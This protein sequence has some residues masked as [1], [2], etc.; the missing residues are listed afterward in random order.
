[1]N[2]SEEY[3]EIDL[4]EPHKEPI[5]NLYQ[6]SKHT[7]YYSETFST[8]CCTIDLDKTKLQTTSK[9]YTEEIPKSAKGSKNYSMDFPDRLMSFKQMLENKKKFL[10]IE[11]D[12]KDLEE[13]TFKPKTNVQIGKASLSSICKK[14]LEYSKLKTPAKIRSKLAQTPCQTH[15]PSVVPKAKDPAVY[16]RL[17]KDSKIFLRGKLQ[18]TFN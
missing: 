16:D 10:K 9:F 8:N 14:Q 6:K 18:R 12:L 4:D 13:C 1:M 2:N 17:Y 7:K 15:R 5:V 3:E 11:Q